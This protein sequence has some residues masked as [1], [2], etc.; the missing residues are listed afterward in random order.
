M[1]YNSWWSGSKVIPLF[2]K[3][4]TSPNLTLSKMTHST[5]RW[6]ILVDNVLDLTVKPLWNTRWESQVKSVKGIRFQVPKISLALL[7]L[8]NYGGDDDQAKSDAGSLAN[9]LEAFEFLLNME[10]LYENLF[11]INIVSKNLQSKSTCIGVTIKEV[12]GIILYFEKYRNGGFEFS[13]NIFKSFA[14]D[15][16][17]ELTLQTKSHRFK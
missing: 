7:K 16:V 5:K 8:Y 4:P 14:F 6:N 12:E 1:S 13:K 3:S 17:I 10:I 11:S 9:S 2:W 15:M